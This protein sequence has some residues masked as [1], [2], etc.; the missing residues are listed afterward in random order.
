[1]GNQNNHTQKLA[2]ILQAIGPVLVLL[3]AIFFEIN[4]IKSYSGW[5]V[6]IGGGLAALGTLWQISRKGGS[7]EKRGRRLDRMMFLGLLLYMVS[8]GFM[9]QGSTIWLPL[10]AVATVFY[11]YALFV[12]DRALRKENKS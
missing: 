4:S 5:L 3:G 12:K 6:A 1:M 2:G 11:I 7:K 8:G 10:F 9:I